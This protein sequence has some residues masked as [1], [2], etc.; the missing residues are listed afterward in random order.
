MRPLPWG[1]RM[2]PSP[3]HTHSYLLEQGKRGFPGPLMAGR[4][5]SSIRQAHA[6]AHAKRSA[7]I[8]STVIQPSSK[9]VKMLARR[10][11]RIGLECRHEF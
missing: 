2:R 6:K 7:I 4:A 3:T 5:T 10:E 11:G 1:R 9:M 8:S